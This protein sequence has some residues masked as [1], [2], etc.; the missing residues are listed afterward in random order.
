[1]MHV[2]LLLLLLD[3]WDA[4]GSGA[5]IRRRIP[6]KIKTFGHRKLSLV[7]GNCFCGHTMS[8]IDLEMHSR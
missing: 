2:T 5:E 1:M 8:D 6:S 4:T 3:F 7:H